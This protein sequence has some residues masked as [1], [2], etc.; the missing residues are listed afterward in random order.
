MEKIVITSDSGID[1]INEENM[2]SGQII[3]DGLDSYRDIVEITPSAILK[4]S[5][6]GHKF[7][8]ASP[9]LSDYQEKF[10]ELL[11]DGNDVIHLSMSSGIS[12]GS[13]NSSN[14]IANM[15]NSEYENKVY[16]VDT[17]TGATGGTLIS[18]IAESYKGEGMTTKEIV[19]ELN[20]I[21][22]NIHTSFYVPNP[23]G[24]IESGRDKSELCMKDKALLHGAT[25]AKKAGIKF[26]VDFNDE[27]NLHTKSLIRTKNSIGML[28]LLKPLVNDETI[29]QYDPNYIVI[30]NI[31][32]HDISMSEL[33][34]YIKQFNYFKHVIN[35]NINGVVAAYGSEDL[36]GISLLKRP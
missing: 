17:L 9:I 10:E 35:K 2:I 13:I 33:E 19:D 28:K 23:K 5:K 34:E 16:V 29:E 32:E 6:E 26:R 15:L 1:P 25:L 8:T 11:E 7:K 12:E 18:E 31:L 36:C 24:F 22:K 14:L 30:G 20:R 21:K 4:Q 27:G 3:R